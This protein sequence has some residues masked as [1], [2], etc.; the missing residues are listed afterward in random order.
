MNIQEGETWCELQRG[1]SLSYPVP[2]NP[3][4]WSPEHGLKHMVVDDRGRLWDPMSDAEMH[5]GLGWVCNAQ[6]ILVGEQVSPPTL[7]K[8][9]GTYLITSYDRS[10]EVEL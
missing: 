7:I 5:E 1:D 4:F 8:L 9:T 10:Q 2:K 6:E 3:I